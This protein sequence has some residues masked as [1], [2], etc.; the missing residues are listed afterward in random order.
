MTSTPLGEVFILGA[1]PVARA[2]ARTL[3][4]ARH[5]PLRLWARRNES[6]S[7]AE[8]E[9]GVPATAERWPDAMRSADTLLFAVRDDAIGQL[10]VE[11]QCAGMLDQ[12]KTLLHCAGSLAAEDAFGGISVPIRGFGLC[13]PLRAIPSAMS[14]DFRE[15]TFAVQ[16]DVEG[17]AAAKSLVQTLGASS[18][19]LEGGQ[20]PAYHAAAAVASNYVVA[21]MDLARDV[22][23]QAG[24]GGADAER[25]FASLAMG[26]I[27][28]VSK[29]GLPQALTG[30]IRRGDADT[31]RGHLSALSAG[32]Q[33]NL[34]AYRV[35]GRRCL[36]L[37]T[38][39]GDAEVGKLREIAALLA[40]VDLGAPANS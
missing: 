33:E 11:L 22:L 20:M 14:G 38:E 40:D 21:L 4:E 31:V 9:T 32:P 25:A 26:A 12:S 24:V 13:H 17:L 28:N 30:P 8:L 6:A 29:R 39:C 5:G 15:T 10:A 1:G 7:E 36:A 3:R 34:E 2:I 27:A 18:I 37:A 19:E 16:G 23:V 35:L